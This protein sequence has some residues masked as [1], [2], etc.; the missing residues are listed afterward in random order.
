MGGYATMKVNLLWPTQQA[1][2]TK[3]LPLP[4]RLLPWPSTRH[5]SHQPSCV[6]NRFHTAAECNICGIG[7][8]K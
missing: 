5:D 4:R 8:T 1:I 6:G 7:H 3:N 2:A